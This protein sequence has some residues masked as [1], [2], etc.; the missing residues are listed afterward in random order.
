MSTNTDRTGPSGLIMG[1]RDQVG[2]VASNDK[3]TIPQGTSSTITLDYINQ[4]ASGPNPHMAI[5]PLPSGNSYIIEAHTDEIFND[6]PLN[7]EGIL[8]YNFFPNGNQYS[9]L[10]FSD[11]DKASKYGLVA[12]SGTE[13]EFDFASANLDVG[14]TFTDS[15]NITISTLSKTATSVTVA[16]SNNGSPS[17][18]C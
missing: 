10:T 7:N 12:T 1:Q 11:L 4:P 18:N 13:F 9:Y 14:E 3:V 5:V 6:T 16:I 8:M 17:W 2:W 15:N